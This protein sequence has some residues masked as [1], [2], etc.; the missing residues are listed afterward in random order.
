MKDRGTGSD[1][2]SIREAEEKTENWKEKLQC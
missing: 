1:E 2:Q